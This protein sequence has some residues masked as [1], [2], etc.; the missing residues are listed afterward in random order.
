MTKKLSKGQQ[1]EEILRIYFLKSGYF[2]E[3]GIPFKY[4]DFDVTDI[5]LWMYNR[6]SSVSREISIVDI[7]NKKTPQAI[8]RIFWV[9]GLQSAVKATNAI[10]AT[11]EKRPDVKDFGKEMNVF[12]LNGV[13]LD[14]IKKFEQE[15]EYRITNEDFYSMISG[16]SL[17]KLD[18]DWKGKVLESKALLAK[19][20][21]FDNLNRLIEIARFFAQQT[22]TKPS[23]KNLAL[24]CFYKLCSYVAINI[25]YLQ[26]D[27]SFLEDVDARQKAFVE[28]FRYGA[29]GERSIKKIVDMSLSFVEQYSENGK[30]TANQARYNINKQ[31]EDIQT[32]ILA[33]YFS[34]HEVLQGMFTTALKFEALSMQK[35]FSSHTDSTVE[36]KSFI[37]ALLDYYS[38]D[39]VKFSENTK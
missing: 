30:V 14:K 27:L 19:G 39:R 4:G 10:V 9:K 29:S 1:L 5:D 13:F 2:V 20:L 3:R 37:G 24:R 7:K 18:G 12:V 21:N 32:N 26:R 22:I 36:V 34:K 35:E 28:G 16:Y 11:T 38:I 6:S 33:E 15:I 31:L 8:E 25:D 17:E 23:Q